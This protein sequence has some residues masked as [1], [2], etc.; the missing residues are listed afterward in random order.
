MDAE[1]DYAH[2]FVDQS[3]T[4]TAGK[5]AGIF[6]LNHVKPARHRRGSDARQQHK[7]PDSRQAGFAPAQD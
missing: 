4:G 6:I 2:G 3:S 7:I 1:F 5:P